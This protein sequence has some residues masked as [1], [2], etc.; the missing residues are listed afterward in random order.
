[1]ARSCLIVSTWLIHMLNDLPETGMRNVARKCLLD[2]CMNVL[3]YS[4]NLEEKV[5]AFLAM[6]SFINDPGKSRFPNGSCRNDFPEI[7][8]R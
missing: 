4:R 8:L 2:Q 3:Q 6:K 1:M 7:L 5:L